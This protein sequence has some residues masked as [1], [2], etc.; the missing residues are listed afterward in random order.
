[1]LPVVNLPYVI[2][3]LGNAKE[4]KVTVSSGAR[5]AVQQQHP[6]SEAK[7]YPTTTKLATPDERPEQQ[8][9]QRHKIM[10]RI[11]T[12]EALDKGKR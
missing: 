9:L 3:H 12:Q 11:S 5:T 8:P 6:C 4:H 2:Q 7:G 10:H 1:M